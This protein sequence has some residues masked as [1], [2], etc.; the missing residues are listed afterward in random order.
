M[1]T[2]NNTTPAIRSNKSVTH[3]TQLG[4]VPSQHPTKTSNKHVT[5]QTKQQQGTTTIPYV[6]SMLFLY[7]NMI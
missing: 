2:H 6:T 3:C 4:N 5:P 1:Q 7:F